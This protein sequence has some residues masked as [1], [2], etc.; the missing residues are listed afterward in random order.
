MRHFLFLGLF[1]SLLLTACN[2]NN[3]EEFDLFMKQFNEDLSFQ[4]SRVIFPLKYEGYDIETDSLMLQEIPEEEWEEVDLSWDPSY[5]TR[6]TDAYD[7]EIIERKDTTIV[8]FQGVNNG[9]NLE[10]V[11][12][13]KKGKWFLLHLSDRSM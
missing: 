9:I 4:K 12:V 7:R 3:V 8:H 13:C 10:A 1:L 6:E 2:G 11:F 5:K